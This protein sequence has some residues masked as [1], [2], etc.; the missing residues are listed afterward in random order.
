MQDDKLILSHKTTFKRN[1][2]MRETWI[3]KFL[4]CETFFEAS[5]MYEA[6][7]SSNRM[8]AETFLKWEKPLCWECQIEPGSICCSGI[9]RLSKLSMNWICIFMS[10]DQNEIAYPCLCL[11]FFPPGLP[12]LSLSS[13]YM[14]LLFKLGLVFLAVWRP[15]IKYPACLVIAV[16]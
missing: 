10:C 14:S 5:P 16:V 7:E 3:W 12:H 9:L 11:Q 1:N 15:F 4:W 8:T 13:A 6:K 2:V